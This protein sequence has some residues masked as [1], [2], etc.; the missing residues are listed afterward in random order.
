MTKKETSNL[1]NEK[2]MDLISMLYSRWQ[3]EKEYEDINDYVERF[4]KAI[5][6]TISGTKRPFG[7]NIQCSDGVLKLAVK[8]KGG[9]LITSYTS[10]A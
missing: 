10:K 6:G 1:I 5:P 8:V 4:K 3:D 7:F 9:Y 2:H